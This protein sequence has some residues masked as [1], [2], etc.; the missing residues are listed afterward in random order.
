MPFGIDDKLTQNVG[1]VATILA[2]TSQ[3]NEPVGH[4]Q[5]VR[6]FDSPGALTNTLTGEIPAGEKGVDILD[7]YASHITFE[8]KYNCAYIFFEVYSSGK[9]FADMPAKLI[10]YPRHQS[11]PGF[12]VNFYPIPL[13]PFETSKINY[14]VAGKNPFF[15]ENGFYPAVRIALDYI[16]EGY[17]F[18][19]H[20]TVESA[21]AGPNPLVI[22]GNLL[23]GYAS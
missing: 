21:W 3:M 9:S 7:Q 1:S 22:N 15:S 18:G 4:I 8:G 19:F 14:A 13:Q 10:V 20:V 5:V 23:H 12:P 17:S 6:T 11:G 16:A 2:N